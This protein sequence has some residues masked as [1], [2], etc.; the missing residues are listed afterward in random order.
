MLGIKESILKYVGV[1]SNISSI[2]HFIE[3]S[4]TRVDFIKRYIFKLKEHKKDKS[5][6]L[7]SLYVENALNKIGLIDWCLTPT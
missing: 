6:I 5:L 3:I 2:K 4:Y 7:R 1:L